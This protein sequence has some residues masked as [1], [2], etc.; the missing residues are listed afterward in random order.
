MN[1]T[2]LV[3]DV[4]ERE[5]LLEG[6]ERVGTE[7]ERAQAQSRAGVQELPLGFQ[8][9]L[10]HY[11]LGDDVAN[12]L[13]VIIRIDDEGTAAAEPEFLSFRV[14]FVE[15]YLAALGDNSDDVALDVRVR[16]HAMR[17][18][19]RMNFENGTAATVKAEAGQIAVVLTIEAELPRHFGCEV[20]WVGEPFVQQPGV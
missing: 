1:A 15:Q 5:R 4:Q 11:I 12:R 7:I 20:F 18:P 14:L 17:R 6:R 2:L 19:Y 8:A 13:I 3:C 10:A 16:R 9:F